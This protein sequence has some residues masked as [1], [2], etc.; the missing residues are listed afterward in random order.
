MEYA[1]I[2]P[3]AAKRPM[4]RLDSRFLDAEMVCL[5]TIPPECRVLHPIFPHGYE[6]LA[7]RQTGQNQHQADVQ[8]QRSE[9]I[10]LQ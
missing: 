9:S 1:V 10:D 3:G 8:A 2:V 6:H 7:L 4:F 5:A